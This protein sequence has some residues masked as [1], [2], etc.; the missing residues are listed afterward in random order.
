M[1]EVEVSYAF[2][3]PYGEIVALLT[4]RSIIEYQETFDVESV[5]ET[6]DGWELAVVNEDIRPDSRSVLEFAE[7]DRGYVY[8]QGERG[9]FEE[10]RTEITVDEG[11][12]TRIIA[13][14]SF[15]FGGPFAFLKD[16]FAAAPRREELERFMANLAR[17]LEPSEGIVAEDGDR[18]ERPSDGRSGASES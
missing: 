16:W 13:R 12:R 15:T 7:T 11:E 17:E 3:A 1:K 10:L 14:S 2:T 4:P 6:A 18:L 9:V 8:V 5:E